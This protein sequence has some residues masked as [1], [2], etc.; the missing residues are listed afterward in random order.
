MELK[1]FREIW[2][3]MQEA[4]SMQT[5]LKKQKAFRKNK[6]KILM[7]RKR[8]MKKKNLDPAKLQKRAE[9][10]ARNMVAKKMLKDTDKSDLGMS[11]KQALEKKLDKKKSVIKKLAKKLLPM[12]RKK[13]QMKNKKEGDTK[14]DGE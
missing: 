9:K 3:E 1:S 14:K 4:D 7:K 13:E 11:G 6:A 10:Q 8:A 5:R 12:I 2:E